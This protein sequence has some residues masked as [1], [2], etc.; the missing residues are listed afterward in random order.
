MPPQIHPFD[1]F[2]LFW[3]FLFNKYFP[4]ALL[5]LLHFPTLAAP[6]IF[7][8]FPSI[9]RPFSPCL[10]LAPVQKFNAIKSASFCVSATRCCN[11]LL[12]TH[13]VDLFRGGIVARLW[14]IVEIWGV[15]VRN[16][17]YSSVE[18]CLKSRH[19][20]KLFIFSTK[21]G[22]QRQMLFYLDYFYQLLLHIRKTCFIFA[23]AT[24]PKALHV[25]SKTFRP[26]RSGPALVLRHAGHASATHE[27]LKT[28]FRYTAIPT[29]SKP[30]PPYTF[31]ART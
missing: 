22:P 11:L 2:C 3:A 8:P 17:A 1:L 16:T 29:L 27:E 18:P 19:Y 7:A 6:A 23:P 9:W 20:L 30:L 5:L 12:F 25:L 31:P 26:P 28:A 4:P 10:V 13:F 15:S 14:Q 21:S 24:H